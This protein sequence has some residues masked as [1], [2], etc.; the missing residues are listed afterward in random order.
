MLNNLYDQFVRALYQFENSL[1]DF[2]HNI[3]TNDGIPLKDITIDSEHSINGQ[4][5]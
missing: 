1:F 4:Q 3:S 5:Y 2:K